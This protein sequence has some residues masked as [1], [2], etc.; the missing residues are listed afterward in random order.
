M[1]GRAR[2]GREL[3][4][5]QILVGWDNAVE[6]ETIQSF[7]NIGENVAEVCG[8]AAQF[9]AAIK[10]GHYD[11]ILLALNFPT[12][13]EC[14]ALFQRVRRE[15]P[16]T[17]IVG[18]WFQGELSHIAKFILAGLHSYMLRDD[19][20]EF[21]MLLTT[22]VEAAHQSVLARRARLLADK[23][24][25]EVESVR[26]LQES[27]IPASLPQMEGYNIV[28]RYEPSEIRVI[29]D[30]PV[31]M[32]G[33]DYYDAFRV[34]DNTPILILGGAAGHGKRACMSIMTMDTPNGRIRDPPHPDNPEVRTAAKTPL[35]P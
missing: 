29:G 15:R 2:P 24:R 22:V 33:G 19:C 10:T 25:E 35:R 26:Q 30:K 7:L 5:M 34:R 1:V 3:G 13:Q 20:G 23:L 27:V 8:D 16:D 32:A 31:V 28:A 18:A 17:P 21:I 4:P 9:E 14:F 6:R 12:Q 11:V